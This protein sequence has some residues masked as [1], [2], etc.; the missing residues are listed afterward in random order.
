M[1]VK[2]TS[3]ESDLMK[4]YLENIDRG[5]CDTQ[6]ICAQISVPS[7]RDGLYN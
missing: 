5:S 6:Y 4:L 1:L 3:K 7:G 2:K